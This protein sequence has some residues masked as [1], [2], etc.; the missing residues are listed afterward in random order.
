[1]KKSK[2]L[3]PFSF[4]SLALLMGIAGTMAFAPIG[5]TTTPIAN[6][7]EI[8]TESGGLITPKADDPI[9][10]TTE[11]G[12]EIKWGNALPSTY[13]KH[14]SSGNL[15]Y[16][17]Y[18]TTSNGSTIY[19]WVII[20]ISSS[21]TI[22]GRDFYSQTPTL[23]SNTTATK[24]AKFRDYYDSS[25]K[26]TTPAGTAIAAENSK[27]YMIDSVVQNAEIPS[28]CVLALL[29]SYLDSS[30]WYITSAG[31]QSTSQSNEDTFQDQERSTTSTTAVYGSWCRPW[32]NCYGYTINDTFGFGSDLNNVQIPTLQQRGY[33]ANE[34]TSTLTATLLKFFPLGGSNYS[35]ENFKWQTYLTA[36]Q[37]K[38]SVAIWGRSMYNAS[39]PYYTNTSGTV[40]YYSSCKSTAYLR[41][42]CILKI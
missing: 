33:S 34:G 1:M 23:V 38:T 25:I 4:T 14:L 21:F 32:S 30:A 40:S 35:S 9:I 22:T 36:T 18:F 31:A 12:L 8:S 37:Y 24:A 42:A 10:Y 7:N 17:P 16:F 29:N 27:Q 13:N 20:G 2:F 26:D 28:G 15:N 19:T 11:S 3:K 39:S 41:P 6:A 5:T